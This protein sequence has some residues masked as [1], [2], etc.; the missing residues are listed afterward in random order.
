M[1]FLLLLFIDLFLLAR[2]IILDYLFVC[3]L[4]FDVVSFFLEFISFLLL[5]G[6]FSSHSFIIE[7]SEKFQ[8]ANE[9]PPFALIDLIV[10]ERFTCLL[11]TQPDGNILQVIVKCKMITT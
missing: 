10:T 1:F 4:T 2:D 3:F 11:F 9:N 5:Y 6:I 8:S 7:I